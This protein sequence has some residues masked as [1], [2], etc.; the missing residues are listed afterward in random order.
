[1][2]PAHADAFSVELQY[3]FWALGTENTLKTGVIIWREKRWDSG[4]WKQNS[5][6]SG[7]HDTFM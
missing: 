6:Q 3:F 5:E 2:F 7:L 4:E 1:M